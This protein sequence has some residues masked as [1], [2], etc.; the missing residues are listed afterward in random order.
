MGFRDLSQTGV[1]AKQATPW[2]PPWQTVPRST[3]LELTDLKELVWWPV[4]SVMLL[5]LETHVLLSRMLNTFLLPQDSTLNLLPCHPKLLSSSSFHFSPYFFLALH[6][7]V[8]WASPGWS[9]TPAF[10]NL[11]FCQ[12]FSSQ[13]MSC[14][15]QT[16]GNHLWFLSSHQPYQ[17]YLQNIPRSTQNASMSHYARKKH[18]C[19]SQH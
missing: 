18:H 1:P 11:F 2:P 19:F 3:W 12:T 4:G 6:L 10:S 17:F 7:S 14:S 5:E 16:P 15:N 8:E 13:E 9:H